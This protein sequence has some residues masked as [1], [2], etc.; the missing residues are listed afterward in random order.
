M[1]AMLYTHGR[2]T[3]KLARQYFWKIAINGSRNYSY[4]YTDKLQD[5]FHSPDCP[6][7]ASDIL[8]IMDSHSRPEI[9]F[10]INLLFSGQQTSNVANQGNTGVGI[11][12]R[13]LS[14][15]GVLQYHRGRLHAPDEFRK[16]NSPAA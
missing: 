9:G 1:Q 2:D 6:N 10:D 12:N 3:E 15:L 13:P 16:L 7:I 5:K 14:D 4:L 11:Y 8:N